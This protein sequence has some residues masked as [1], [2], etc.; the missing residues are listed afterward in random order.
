MLDDFGC[1]DAHLVSQICHSDNFRQ[2]YAPLDGLGGCDFRLAWLWLPPFSPKPARPPVIVEISPEKHFLAPTDFP[3]FL[4][5]PLFNDV[6]DLLL[7]LFRALL[8]L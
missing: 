2:L 5:N 3:F 4:F 6:A 1:L 7:F 8:F